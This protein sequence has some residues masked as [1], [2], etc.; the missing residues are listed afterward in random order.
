MN[1]GYKKLIHGIL[2]PAFPYCICA[3][4]TFIF[5]GPH[6]FM[7]AGMFIGGMDVSGSL[8]WNQ[9]F[10]K[11][12]FLSGSL[13]LW[14]P[15]HY[16]GHPFLA[17]PTTFVFY[18]ATL[19]YVFLPLPH[20]FT[21]DTVAHFLIASIGAYQLVHLL[22]RSK[23]AGIASAVVYSLSGYFVD[24]MFAGHLT[25]IHTAALIPWIFYC[26]EKG[27]AMNR[28]CLFLLTGVLL[29]MQVLAGDP[30]V[31]LYTA[32][33]LCL[34]FIIRAILFS[35]ATRKARVL[36]FARFLIVPLAAFGVSAVQILPSFEFMQLSDRTENPYEFVTLGSF[37]LRQLFLFLVPKAQTPLIN[38][39]WEFGCYLGIMS[40]VLAFI[41]AMTKQCRRLTLCLC[42]LLFIALTFVLGGFTPIYQLYY[43]YLPFISTFRVPARCL[44]ILDFI[45]AIFV[46][47]GVHCVQEKGFA[48]SQYVLGMG[49]FAVLAA[50][51]VAGSIVFEIPIHSGQIITAMVLMTSGIVVFHVAYVTKGSRLATALIIMV[52]FVDLAIVHSPLIPRLSNLE[53]LEKKPYEVVFEKDTDHFRVNI[54]G[55]LEELYGLPNRGMLY[56]YSSINA[57]TPIVVKD[58]FDFIYFMAGVPQPMMSR[59]TFSEELFLPGTIFS[60]RILGVKYAFYKTKGGYSMVKADHYQ[61]RAKLMRDVLFTPEYRGQLAILKNQEFRPYETVLL[62]ES[63]KADVMGGNVN[64]GTI[65]QDDVHIVS[66]SLNRIELESTSP[67]T[68]ILL[69]SELYYPG[70]KAYVDGK[71]TPIL[72]ADYLLRAVKLDAGNHSISMVYRPMSFIIGLCTT[73]CTAL[74]LGASLLHIIVSRR[75]RM[76]APQS[77]QIGKR[78]FRKRTS[79]QD[80]STG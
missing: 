79:R 52:L 34:Y 12:A 44:V 48:R 22:T 43:K 16:S 71:K 30:Q 10:T 35:D 59:H 68:T 80:H 23:E 6:L 45:L 18:P 13:P 49:A 77:G 70:W 72:R 31:N 61:P 58:Y 51:L 2:H 65:A 60:S 25:L 73:L 76:S 32:M 55:H 42:I 67:S 63:D 47:L 36:S 15:Y 62:D 8:Y 56:R 50:V 4:F 28:T 54:P 20:A 3:L 14:N 11:D 64:A 53:L 57:S 69:L 17:N 29:G 38:T 1:A 9:A 7:R 40:I 74:F 41:G 33:F 39:N 5:F 19:L 24:R 21:I 37:S 66:Y 46:G 75:Q 26:L 27:W 78:Q